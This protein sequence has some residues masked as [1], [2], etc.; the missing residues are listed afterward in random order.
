MPFS[1][2]FPSLVNPCLSC[3]S[4]DLWDSY[5]KLSKHHTRNVWCLKLLSFIQSEQKNILHPA[6]DHV[7][8]VPVLSPQHCHK[9]ASP[10]AKNKHKAFWGTVPW[11]ISVPHAFVQPIRMHCAT[12]PYFTSRLTQVS[13]E[14]WAMCHHPAALHPPPWGLCP[15]SLVA[16]QH[17]GKDRAC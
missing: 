3:N 6:L 15:A 11:F 5:F 1:S 4:V 9:G 10:T 17:D 7:F 14:R 8:T 12:C 2:L 16:I 13:E